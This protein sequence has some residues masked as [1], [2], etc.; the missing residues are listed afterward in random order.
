MV[1]ERALS[2][3]NSIK[4][5]DAEISASYPDGDYVGSIQ[6]TV[7]EN[8]LLYGVYR[9]EHVSGHKIVNLLR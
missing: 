4:M 9:L 5:I 6:I 2:N 8:K 7:K 1:G 3:G